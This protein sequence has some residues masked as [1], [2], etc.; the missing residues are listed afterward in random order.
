MLHNFQKFILESKSGRTQKIDEFEA[1][2]LL[3]Q[4]S[5]NPD[6]VPIYRGVRK[7][8][9]DYGI[10]DP[11]KHLRKAGY[12]NTSYLNFF[13]NSP[14][15]EDYPKRR[16]SIICTTSSRTARYF[17]EKITKKYN[18]YG[19]VYRVIPLDVKPI[20]GICPTFDF[21]ESFD[22]VTR[23]LGRGIYNIQ[24]IITDGGRSSTTLSYP[25]LKTLAKV[26]DFDFENL[27][28]ITAPEKNDFQCLPYSEMTFDKFGTYPNLEVWTESKSLLIKVG[29]ESNFLS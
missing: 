19:D 3:Q 15:W 6:L 13:D 26:Y 28:K 21:Q 5:Y 27:L 17:S 22:N 11:S 9:Q 20:F 16:K 14:Y 8:N 4:S 24:M 1:K 25:E 2:E 18:N 7:Y 29:K 23:E 12:S 10:V